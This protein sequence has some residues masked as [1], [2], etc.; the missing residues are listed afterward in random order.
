MSATW[1]RVTSRGA[2]TGEPAKAA[3]TPLNPESCVHK[4]A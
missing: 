3:P 1:T 4:E 2:G